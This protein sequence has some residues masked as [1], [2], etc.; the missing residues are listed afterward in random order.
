MDE[1]EKYLIKSIEEYLRK[2]MRYESN[3]IKR[4]KRVR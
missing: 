3:T 4:C 2:V 1:A